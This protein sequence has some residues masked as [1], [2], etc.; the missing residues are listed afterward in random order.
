MR[1]PSRLNPRADRFARGFAL[2]AL[3]VV[4]LAAGA[5]DDKHIGRPCQLGAAPPDAGTSGGAFA[6]V[7]S[8]ALECPSRICVLPN[9]VNGD[10][11]M[12][13][14]SAF[15]TASCSTD[16]DCSDA[17]TG[18]KNNP[19]DTHCKTNFV[20]TWPTTVGPFCCQKMCICHDFLIV[21]AGGIPEPAVCESPG[22]GG[23]NPPT[24]QNVH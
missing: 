24:C 10:A 1:F 6:T 23:P 19:T 9:D 7:T 15:C 4:I 2:V 3:G 16:D 11:T 8:P 22:N 18:D 17:E 5:C 14:E 12:Y 21:P 20:C 13:H